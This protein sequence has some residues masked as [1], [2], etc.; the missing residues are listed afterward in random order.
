MREG[1]IVVG[2]PLRGFR[3]VLTGIPEKLADDS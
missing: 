3:G 2:E 1:K